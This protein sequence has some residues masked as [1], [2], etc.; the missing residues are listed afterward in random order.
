[1]TCIACFIDN[2]YQREL[3]QM[4]FCLDRF[5]LKLSKYKD[6]FVHEVQELESVSKCNC[7]YKNTDEK[8]VKWT[9]DFLKE[10]QNS[11]TVIEST[12][13]ALINIYKSYVSE[14]IKIATDKVWDFLT[15]N[16]LLDETEGGFSYS[17]LFYRAR[18]DDGSFN[19]NDITNFFHIPFT[20]RELIGN[21][22][23]SISG[24][25]MLYFAKSVIGVEKELSTPINK[26]AISAFI[27]Y[28]KDFY[29]KKYFTIKNSLFNTIVKS[30]PGILKSGSQI[31]YY[32][33]DLAP[34]HNS[35]EK[36]LQKSIL[37]QVLTF[38]VENKH[39]FIAE[40]ILPQMVT[41][42]LLENG[43]NG[44]AFPSTKDFTELK[45]Y[46]KFSDFESNFAV[47]V[48]YSPV[49][50]YDN[51]LLKSFLYFTFN[52]QEQFEYTAKEILD[53]FEQVAELNKKSKKDN[54]M[55]PLGNLQL[56]IEYLENSTLNGV[57]YFETLQGKTELEF[58]S[59]V[60][61][62]YLKILQ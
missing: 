24:Q 38:P 34:N 14:N 35:L 40:Y 12:F 13:D 11:N 9:D 45:S 54:F 47:F 44:V 1:M 48:K 49:N 3:K 21:Q 7:K 52:G 50:S 29:S 59:K 16:D 26:L 19:K 2:K 46:H 51:D 30:L 53:K 36:D 10:M 42:A 33:S 8:Y 32:K 20:K 23:F 37:S 18:V 25:P 57:N 22:R 58:H 28:F 15:Y 60:A 55:V 41:T 39:S 5:E 4:C 61:D 27:P 6:L 31:D 56:H 17:T 62:F 43:Y